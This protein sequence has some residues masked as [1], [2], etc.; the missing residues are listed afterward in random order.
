M[1][2]LE[3]VLL[4]LVLVFGSVCELKHEQMIQ[5]LLGDVGETPTVYGVKGLQVCGSVV[6]QPDP[7][8]PVTPFSS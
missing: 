6:C 7:S 1:V 4:T 3:R 2:L 8:H 5:D